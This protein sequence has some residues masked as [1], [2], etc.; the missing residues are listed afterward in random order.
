MHSYSTLLGRGLYSQWHS[1]GQNTGAFPFSVNL[2]NP[3]NEPR[4]PA[5]RADSLLSESPGE[6]QLDK[7][8]YNI[9]N[10]KCFCL[11][12]QGGKQ[13]TVISLTVL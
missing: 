13:I 12:S 11:V 5:M 4:S 7:I 6:A 8:I 3:G 10:E 1:P 9:S 2:P